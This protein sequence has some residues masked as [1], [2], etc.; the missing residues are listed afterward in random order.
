MGQPPSE[1]AQ[2]RVREDGRDVRERL[3]TLLTVDHPAIPADASLAE[4]DIATA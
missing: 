4:S 2:A 3:R 1:H